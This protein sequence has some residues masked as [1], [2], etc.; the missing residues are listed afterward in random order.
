[1]RQTDGIVEF[2]MQ[3]ARTKSAYNLF[4]SLVDEQNS[5]MC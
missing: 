3:Y 5:I 4:I 2:I 1:M